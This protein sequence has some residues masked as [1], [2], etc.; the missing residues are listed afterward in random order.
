MTPS[1]RNE[2]K[3]PL[4]C[5]HND[6]AFVVNGEPANFISNSKPGVW[7][8]KWDSSSSKILMGSYNGLSYLKYIKGEWIYDSELSGFG[9]HRLYEW[10]LIFVFH[11][12][13]Y[14]STDKS[15]F[16][17]SSDVAQ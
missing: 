12:A 4:F 8:F 16:S 5:G 11:P 13:K 17:I 6:G 10:T 1:S 15:N 7:D 9:I 3:C 14:N 2:F